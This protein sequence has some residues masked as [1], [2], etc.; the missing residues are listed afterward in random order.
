MVQNFHEIAKNHMNVNFRD[1]NFVIATFFFVITS[2]PRHPRGQFMLS[3]R[4]QF[5]H[6]ALGL[7]RIE[8]ML[9]RLNST[10]ASEAFNPPGRPS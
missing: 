5:L 10:L 8:I 9:S 1:K 7:V 2:A 3:L 4:P 6:V